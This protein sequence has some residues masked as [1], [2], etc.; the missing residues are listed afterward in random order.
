MAGALTGDPNAGILAVLNGL[1][2]SPFADFGG[3]PI[4]SGNAGNISIT[5]SAL[6]IDGIHTI[7]S[8]TSSDGNG[9]TLNIMV[10]S[11]SL[12][13]GAEIRSRS[14]LIDENTGELRVGTGNGGSLNVIANDAIYMANGSSISTSSLGDGLAGNI[15]IDAG[16]TF[17]IT[18]SSI[19]SQAEGAGNGGDISVTASDA[20]T[21]QSSSTIS[22]SSLGAG[23]AGNISINSGNTF[24]MSGSSIT[25]Q[26]EGAGN[27]GDINVL[28]SNAVSMAS[29]SS[30]SASSLGAG[31]AGNI[32]I[33]GGNTFEMSGSSITTQAIES[34]GGDIQIVAL[35]M[36]YLDQSEITTSVE[37]G[38]G[39]GGNID[40]D[41]EFVILK[42]SNILANAFGGPGGNINIVAGN[43][44]ATPDSTVDASSALGI[45][46]TVNISS[47]DETISEDLAVLSKNYLDVTSLMSDRC[48]T[49][50]GASSLVDAGPGGRAIDPDGYLPSFAANTH[51]NNEQI[52]GDKSASNGNRW[53]A[54]YANQPAL[55]VA[56]ITC[57]Y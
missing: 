5:A 38:T 18:D 6:S 57:T 55:Q 36:V 43:F 26:A 2:M 51:N 22:A 14:G 21:M 16:N 3:V 32:S 47:P 10:D 12:D 33:D 1:D 13:N 15:S 49:T 50:A 23:T 45:D 54:T 28:A 17:N 44:I 53:W 48:G 34:D 4:V 7:S 39:G 52:K 29:G 42:Q 37:S 56:Q 35:K 20:V 40:I 46:G 8:S 41:P 27:G 30:I 24:G 11:L 9:G 31:T 19:T 25:S